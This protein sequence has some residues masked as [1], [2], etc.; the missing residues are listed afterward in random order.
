MST[1]SALQIVVVEDKEESYV[2]EAKLIDRARYEL[3]IALE[4]LQK[5]DSVKIF[6][7]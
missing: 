7:N 6:L 4:A 3:K 1:N 2:G 5:I